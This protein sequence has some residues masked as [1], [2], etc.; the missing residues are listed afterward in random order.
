[1]TQDSQAKIYRERIDEIDAISRAFFKHL[2]PDV[3]AMNWIQPILDNRKSELK[4]QFSGDNQARDEQYV[5][6]SATPVDKFEDYVFGKDDIRNITEASGSEV[7]YP[8]DSQAGDEP[9]YLHILGNCHCKAGDMSCWYLRNYHELMIENKN[10]F[11]SA[12]NSLELRQNA[13][14]KELLDRLATKRAIAELKKA[15]GHNNS[16]YTSDYLEDRIAALQAE[17][18]QLEGKA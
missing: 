2:T 5:P 9:S 10:D 14:M 3:T 11:D 12:N 7:I 18:Q 8:R 4:A 6:A 13:A 17:L 1:M 16:E 15:A